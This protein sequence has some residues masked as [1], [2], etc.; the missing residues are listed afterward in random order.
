MD[1]RDLETS[2]IPLVI[3]LSCTIFFIKNESKKVVLFYDVLSLYID[4]NGDIV[5][6][7]IKYGK[8]KKTRGERSD[9]MNRG[10][11]LKAIPACSIH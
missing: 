3:S 9:C 4:L 8:I 6:T 10:H 7:E 1:E 5:L 2:R 11:S